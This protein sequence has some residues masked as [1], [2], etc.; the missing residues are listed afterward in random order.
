MFSAKTVC[1]INFL[2]VLSFI[3]TC[4]TIFVGN[5][6]IKEQGYLTWGHSALHLSSGCATIELYL[7]G[8][9]SR[10]LLD[11]KVSLWMKQAFG[12]VDVN[13]R[14]CV[15]ICACVSICVK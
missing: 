2:S 5:D 4:P 9:E 3:A 1:L 7:G 11:M 12:L 6:L 10:D 13:S 8:T 15:C 14:V